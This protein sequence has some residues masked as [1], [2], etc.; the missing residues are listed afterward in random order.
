MTKKRTP[1]GLVGSEWAIKLAERAFRRYLGSPRGWICL[2]RL[3][4]QQ[5]EHLRE[6]NDIYKTY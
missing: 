5:P 6:F 3:A 2:S 1:M 4:D